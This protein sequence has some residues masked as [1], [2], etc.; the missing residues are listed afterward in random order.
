MIEKITS[1][2]EQHSFTLSVSDTFKI[3]INFLLRSHGQVNIS[4]NEFQI[5]NV[6]KVEVNFLSFLIYLEVSGGAKFEY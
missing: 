6:E 4:N 2:L 1:F 3:S 5:R